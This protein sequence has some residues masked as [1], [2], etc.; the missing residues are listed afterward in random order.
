MAVSQPVDSFNHSSSSTN[1]V[2][3]CFRCTRNFNAHL[4]LLLMSALVSPVLRVN[5]GLLQMTTQSPGRFEYLLAGE[6]EDTF[7]FV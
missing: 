2:T 3:S 7:Y 5:T 1:A 6:F 4:T